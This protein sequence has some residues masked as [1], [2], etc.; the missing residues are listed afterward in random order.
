MLK[1]ITRF[2]QHFLI[3]I[4]C[5]PLQLLGT[6]GLLIYLPVHRLIS[7][8]IQ[9]PIVFRWFDN[10]DIYPEFNRDSSTYRQI[11][12]QG[13]FIQYCWL[14]WR[15]PLNYF[16]YKIL[17]TE[18]K[19]IGSVLADVVEV[20]YNDSM[21]ILVADKL[22]HA[23]IGDATDQVPGYHFVEV[24]INDQL[25]YEYYYIKKYT[26]F[27]TPK[28]FRFRLGS[29]ITDPKTLQLGSYLQQV[30]VISPFHSY[31]GV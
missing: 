17:G 7:N 22:K 28:C 10:A 16:G 6:L 9:L 11:Y 27:G 3:F 14:A 13:W 26:F 30:F 15:N 21:A 12:A 20:S 19:E 1:F 4:L 23:E 2:I 31:S 18:I 5:L 25:Y 29:K 8:N 24:M